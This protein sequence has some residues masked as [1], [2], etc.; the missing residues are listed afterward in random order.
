MVVA[1]VLMIWCASSG[2]GRAGAHVVLADRVASVAE[3]QLAFALEDEEHFLFAMVAM[4]P[5]LDLAGRQD[6]QVVAELPSADVTADLAPA[7]RVDLVLLDTV[8][9]DLVEV[10]DG[11]HHD[12]PTDVAAP[13]HP[14]VEESRM[15]AAVCPTGRDP[16]RAP[17]APFLGHPSRQNRQEPVAQSA[18][19]VALT[20]R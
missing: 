11:L 17:A 7:R 20:A 4:V 1:P 12:L 18:A 5:A 3:P 16:A 14:C 19:K 6:G 10:D 15:A 9:L 8:E 2:A 13:R